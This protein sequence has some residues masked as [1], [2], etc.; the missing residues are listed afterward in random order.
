MGLAG[1]FLWVPLYILLLEFIE[2]AGRIVER[3]NNE[4]II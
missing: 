1:F 3:Y 4:K 2:S